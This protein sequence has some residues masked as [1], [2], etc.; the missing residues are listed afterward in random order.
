MIE[1]D[2]I[3][4]MISQLTR[5]L[6]RVLLHRHAHEFPLARKELQSAYKSL[7]GLTPSLLHQFSD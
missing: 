3:M 1:R 4:R 5:S 6:A 2:Y 7:L